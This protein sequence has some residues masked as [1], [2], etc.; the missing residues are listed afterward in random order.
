MKLSLQKTFEASRFFPSGKPKREVKKE[1]GIVEY[2]HESTFVGRNTGLTPEEIDT[3]LASV[4]ERASAYPTSQPSLKEIFFLYVGRGK[5]ATITLDGLTFADSEMFGFV[6][7]QAPGKPFLENALS[8]S[9]APFSEKPFESR[10]WERIRFAGN[11]V[12]GIKVIGINGKVE[13]L[14]TPDRGAQISQED[15]ETA[16]STIK[17][18]DVEGLDRILKKYNI[19]PRPRLIGGYNS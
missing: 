16:K 1:Q 11:N 13:M 4:S 2:V 7:I 18:Q 12:T 5:Y 17:R 15:F 6:G 9:Y 8:F 10:Y 19:F 14:P 3:L